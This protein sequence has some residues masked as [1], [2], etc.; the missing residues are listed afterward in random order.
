[1]IEW[2]IQWPGRWGGERERRGGEWESEREQQILEHGIEGSTA[3]C[4][5]KEVGRGHTL[6][7]VSSFLIA[8]VLKTVGAPEATFNWAV[9]RS[10]GET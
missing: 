6:K 4:E 5:P 9:G 8:Q 7:G 2:N 3:N 10:L 1:M